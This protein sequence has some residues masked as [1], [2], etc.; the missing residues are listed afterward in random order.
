[1]ITTPPTELLLLVIPQVAISMSGG[2]SGRH[3]VVWRTISVVGNSIY[4]VAMDRFGNPISNKRSVGGFTDSLR[5]PVV[6]GDGTS[7]LV[8]WNSEAGCTAPP[9]RRSEIVSHTE[10]DRSVLA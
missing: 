3:L 5:R 4:A 2:P 9:L 8:V 7:F 1:M 10:R 6:D